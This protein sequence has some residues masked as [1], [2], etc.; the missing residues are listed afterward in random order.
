[1]R[2]TCIGKL[3]IDIFYEVEKVNI[4][5]N[6]VSNKLEIGVGGKATNVSVALSKLGV[7]SYLIARIGKDEFGHFAI[8]KLQE[9]GVMTLLSLSERTGI[10]FIVVD[11]E[12]NNTMFNFLGANEEL[13]IEDI[14]NH[15]DII[16]NS[17]IVF[18]QAGV[19]PKILEY[20]KKNNNNIFVELTEPIDSELLNGIKYVSLNESEAIKVTG[21]KN[22]EIALS[23]INSMGIEHIFLKRGS[24][25][26]MYCS[27]DTQIYCEPFN[28][29][30]ID[31][32]GAGDA[33]SAGIIYSLLNS[34]TLKETL[35]FANA[36][37]ALACLK[38][39][40]TEI[41]PTIDTVISFLESQLN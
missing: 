21:E 30:P 36:C 1:M 11:K 3:N 12:S 18:F 39:G 31:T 38:K 27:K 33:F 14:E 28:I 2:V 9:F 10:T 29:N 20:L 15:R 19:N 13:C 32:T 37:G 5:Q 40:T 6:H 8:Q 41:F 34:F 22:L 23:K 35:R 17:D 7:N 16:N 4:N 25:G 24:K 26:S